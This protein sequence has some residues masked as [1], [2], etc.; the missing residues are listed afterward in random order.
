MSIWNQHRPQ[1]ILIAGQAGS[2]ERQNVGC[3][4]AFL[5]K[6]DGRPNHYLIVE[7]WSP[8]GDLNALRNS[9]SY[10]TSVLHCSPY[11]LVHSMSEPGIRSPPDH[12][13]SR[14][15]EEDKKSSKRTRYAKEPRVGSSI[16]GVHDLTNLHIRAMLAPEAQAS[17][18]L[19]V[20]IS[21]E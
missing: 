6:E 8:I 13:E 2:A 19:A 17:G 7:R 15:Q 18:F 10:S 3:R 21:W 20:A 4:V 5:I 11:L 14:W 1:A 16:V 9:D 12:S